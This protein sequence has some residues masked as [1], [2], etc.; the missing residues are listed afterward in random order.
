MLTASRRVHFTAK[1]AGSYKAYPHPQL[2]APLSFPSHIIRNH[3]NSQ[4][5]ISAQGFISTFSSFSLGSLSQGVLPGLFFTVRMLPSHPHL[6]Y[7]KSSPCTLQFSNISHSKSHHFTQS[8][9][10]KAFLSSKSGS[11]RLENYAIP[12]HPATSA[13][14]GSMERRFPHPES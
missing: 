5:S 10:S 7:L 2:S 14:H 3:S 1:L 9:A 13:Q 4:G 6:S 8:Q 12:A 11:M